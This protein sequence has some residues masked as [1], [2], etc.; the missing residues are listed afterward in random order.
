M[1]KNS[2]TLIDIKR[3][4]AL[5]NFFSAKGDHTFPLSESLIVLYDF[6]S[7]KVDRSFWYGKVDR[8]LLL[9]H[10]R[11]A[12]ALLASKGRSPF[13]TFSPTAGDRIQPPIQLSSLHVPPFLRGA[14][15]DQTQQLP[16]NP[17]KTL[18]H[19]NIRKPDNFQSIPL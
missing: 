2:I 10:G 16:T 13:T 11:R 7:T 9:F 19:L 5:Y 1:L 12:I 14:R 3:S 17:L 8:I 6:F 15:G 18:Q 4:I